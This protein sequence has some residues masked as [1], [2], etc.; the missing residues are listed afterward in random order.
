ML[1]S[2][3]EQYGERIISMIKGEAKYYS[4]NL[5]KKLQVN[6]NY[7]DYIRKI[8]SKGSPDRY[9]G[10]ADSCCDGP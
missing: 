8:N 6:F 7:T 2:N 3:M 9:G 1:P 10:T 5:K 4:D